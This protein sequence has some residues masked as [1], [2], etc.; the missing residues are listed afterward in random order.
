MAGLADTA[1]GATSY[2]DKSLDSRP[3]K[4]ATDGSNVHTVDFGNL[5]FW[6]RVRDVKH[7]A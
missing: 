3:H 4:W 5:R 2:Y 7:A 6:A 1:G